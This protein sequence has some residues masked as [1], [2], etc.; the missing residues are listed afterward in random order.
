MRCDLDDTL[1]HPTDLKADEVLNFDSTRISWNRADKTAVMKGRKRTTRQDRVY[2]GA[3]RPF[4]KQHVHFDR[5]LNDMV[6]G[7]YAIFPTPGH[8]NRGFYLPKPGSMAPPFMV[9]MTGSVIDNG[10]T[11]SSGA[12]F[13]PRWTWDPVKD[14][15]LQSSLALADSSDEVVV[16]GYRRR[17]NINPVTVAAYRSAFGDDVTSDDVF[18]Y[19]YGLLH[20]P[21]YRAQFAADLKKTLPRIPKVATAEHFRAFVTAGRRLADLHIGCESVDP[22][23]LHIT[24]EPDVPPSVYG[25]LRQLYRVEKMRFGGTG[26]AKDRSTVIYNSNITVSGIPVEAHEYMLGSRSAIERV[27]GRYQV[28]TDKSSGIV[29]DPNDWA[30]EAGSPR[31]ILDLLT[32][33]VT[34]SVETVQIVCSL[35]AIDF[36]A[37][38]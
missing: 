8:Q 19:V 28:K 2:V 13:F 10:A 31:Y 22:Y 12:N 6:Y 27:L 21:D 14:G 36:Q 18:Y 38:A 3:Y 33:V 16:N 25:V 35:R 7:L 30:L 17:D 32:R 20:S 4:N 34:V 37:L 5:D 11:G 9:L 29:N 24:G 26:K 15:Q 23:P 1:K